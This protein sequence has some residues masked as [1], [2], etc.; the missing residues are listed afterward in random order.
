MKDGHSE[1]YPTYDAAMAR[2]E[3]GE[4]VLILGYRLHAGQSFV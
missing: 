3:D 4:H 2:L 1:F